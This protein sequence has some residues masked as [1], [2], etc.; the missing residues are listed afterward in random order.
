MSLPALVLSWTFVS[1][2]GVLSPGPLSAMAFAGGARSGF[3]AG[4]L[5]CT[6]HALLELCLIVGL[7]LGLREVVREEVTNL[8]SLFG[9]GFLVWMGCGL[10]RDALRENME[11]RGTKMGIAP[12]PA[13]VLLSVSNPF[14]LVWWATV[15]MT[16]VGRFLRYGLIGLSAFYVSH[17]LT[18]YVWLSFLSA[19]G[20]SGTQVL[21]RRVHRAILCVCGVFLMAVGLYFLGSGFSELRGSR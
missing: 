17:V 3:R 14:W 1:L 19:A 8:V 4:P 21:G 7:V 9:G 6:G 11:L 5:L 15:G 16:Y 10:F 13:G 20:S 12:I 18:D 2:S